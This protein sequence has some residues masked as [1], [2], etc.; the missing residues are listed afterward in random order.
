MGGV[1]GHMDHLYD[2]PNLTFGKMKEILRA[3]ANAE[4]ET[5]EKVDG[6]NIFLSY[7]LQ[8]KDHIYVP[9][10][11]DDARAAR[12]KGNLLK[13]GMDA[14]ELAEKFA[15]H[16]SPGI[17]NAFTNAF[18]AFEKAVSA[19]SY[20]EKLKVFGPDTD[21]WYN[22]EVMDPGTR[23]EDGQPDHDD[24]G[25]V[26]VIKYDDK[27]IKI[28]GVG[29]F[30][31]DRETGEKYPI[32]RESLETFDA[33]LDK[34]QEKLSDDDF[35]LA[36]NAIIQLQKMEDEEAISQAFGRIN[37]QMSNEGLSDNSTMED[38]VFSRLRNGIDTELPDHLK[39]EIVKYLMKLP[40]NIGLRQL[41]KSVN[42]EDLKDLV[43]IV[44]NKKILLQQAIEPLELAIHDFAVE[45]LK[46][47]KSVFIA[48]TDREVQR[49]RHNLSIAVKDITA[50]GSEDPEMMAVMQRHLNKIKDFS[51][52]N[53]PVEAV[54]F[55]YDGHT[56]KF[57][58]NFA[59]LNQIL[60]MYKYGRTKG[61][62]PSTT[63]E[64]R[65]HT[66]LA[67]NE[68]E[69]APKSTKRTEAEKFVLSLPKFSPSEA[70]GNP[71]SMER[72][73]IQKI[74]D[75]VGGGA[76]IKEKLDFL[77]DSITN[78]KGGIHSPTRI[79]ST[80]IL[81]ESLAAVI[82]SFNSASAG[83][84]FEGFLAALFR[85]RQEAEISAKGNLPI[86]DL[87]AFSE[88]EGG[89]PVPI[90][91]KLL[92]QTTNIEGSYTNLIDALD[93]FG[94]MV[95]I[96][97]RK[98]E[99]KENIVLEKFTF[100]RNNFIDAL[101]SS[102]TGAT[103]KEANLFELPYSIAPGISK[104]MEKIKSI[105]GNTNWPEKYALLQ[106]TKG[107]RS[108][109]KKVPD[110]EV[111][112]SDEMPDGDDIIATDT[113]GDSS[114]QKTTPKTRKSL[115]DKLADLRA[116]RAAA[117]RRDE[118]FL[119]T[120]DDNKAL[121]SEQL[122]TESSKTQWAISPQQLKAL[123]GNLDYEKL[124]TLPISE[125]RVV[126]VAE[127]YMDKLGESLRAIF[128][129][130]SDLSE[131][132]NEYFTYE[133]RSQGISA[134]NEA[135]KD[136][137]V[138]AKEMQQQLADDAGPAPANIKEER[139]PAEKS[140][141]RIA[142][143]PGKFKPPHKGHYDFVNKVARRSD[144]D[145]VVVLISPV[146]KDPVTAQQSLKIWSKFLKS[147]GAASNINIEIA[148]Y[149][150]PVTTVYEF[151]ADPVKARNG[152]TVLLVKSSKDDGDTRFNNAQSYAE[153]H[154]PGVNVQEIEEDPIAS[155]EGLIFSAE[156]LREMI[157]KNEKEKFLSYMPDN[158]DGEE[159]WNIFRP[160]E[161]FKK[162]VDSMIGEMS[163][164]AGGDV[165]GYAGG[166]GP[167]NTYNPYDRTIKKQP[168][169]QP[170]R[171]KVRRAKR[172]RRR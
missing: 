121:L 167:P 5:E 69:D 54:V 10:E 49:L 97:A 103:T 79:I 130:T 110:T 106:Q 11:G 116:R 160:N 66:K 137:Q 138:I 132:V 156:D 55:D 2:N 170:K 14:T 42:P 148:D 120:I 107:Y 18:K 166:F 94:E 153:R 105:D 56:Y 135:I 3:A 122:L 142:L 151:V 8:D 100:D 7:D 84:V 65:I 33:A 104:S 73:Q 21:I 136:S 134:G 147:P 115:E 114:D 117:N 61:K 45:L 74:F 161:D 68:K 162:E 72:K 123:S 63:S 169:K 82:R 40:G 19:L 25:A 52:V 78:P 145:E 48:N 59:P 15:K 131:N 158:V 92:N 101:T 154:N 109:A 28:H 46:G 71:S 144:V 157:G 129:A 70:W 150:S 91:L 165:A 44:N 51:Q 26:N 139:D 22:A 87:I 77:N 81:M 24:P 168:K 111:V 43:D 27:T 95:Y 9:S 98:D 60:G 1:A 4:L 35:S 17:R 89:N 152:D 6:Q 88:L 112:V 36:R 39:D 172:K 127:Q 83:F 50:H 128:A 37:Q 64:A 113:E 164:M 126:E 76:T 159:V 102:A 23:T 155:E 38:Y 140:Q 99:N 80:L 53:T 118:S 34:M 12:N 85:G 62:A 47:L 57:S 163:S 96:V 29:H 93:E 58:G 30:R 20:E 86:Q 124:G 141:K 171:P 16:G 67:I 31:F 75:T 13:A 90:S 125:N 133:D 32:P 143:F 119:Y 146:D 108:R 149:R 41:K